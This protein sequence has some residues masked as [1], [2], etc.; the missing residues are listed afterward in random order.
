MV[1]L[2]IGTVVS[3]PGAFSGPL[4]TLWEKLPKLLVHCVFLGL[5]MLL[6]L[7]SGGGGAS[8]HAE[9]HRCMAE[10]RLL[11]AGGQHCR[12]TSKCLLPQFL[13]Y[14][15]PGNLASDPV[16]TAL[17]LVGCYVYKRDSSTH[18]AIVMYQRK[19]K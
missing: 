6:R 12:K 2:S 14:T 16:I 11:P 10:D 4:L 18:L 13:K 5:M 17:H 19:K 8:S 3:K 7:M 1:A 9:E 15:Y